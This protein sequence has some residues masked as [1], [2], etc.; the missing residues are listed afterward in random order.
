MTWK[1][2][3]QAIEAAGVLD[4][5]VVHAINLYFP[6]TQAFGETMRIDHRAAGDGVAIRL[7]VLSY[8]S[9]S[10]RRALEVGHQ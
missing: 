9:D 8:T 4:G 5:D 3:K 6:F 1:E 10:G 7:S 2:F